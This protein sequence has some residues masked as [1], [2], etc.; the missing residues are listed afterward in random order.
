MTSVTVVV[1]MTIRRRGGRK[2]IIGPDGAPVRAG[3][4][5]AGVTTTRGD[6]ALV[7]ALA[8]AFRWR[9][10][11]E[12]GRHGS[13]R[14]LAAAESVERSV[15]ARTLGLTL[16]APDIVEAI[17]DGREPIALSVAS[18][19]RGLPDAWEVQRTA[20]AGRGAAVPVGRADPGRG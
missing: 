3:G 16:L 1:P 19:R 20:L 15:V 6:P 5:A 13:I 8:R 7:K 10:M 11:L 18:F 14:E 4:D 12:E 17:L 2:Q 9:R